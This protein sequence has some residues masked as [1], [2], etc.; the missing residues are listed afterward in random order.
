MLNAKHNESGNADRNRAETSH[1]NEN[2]N[3]LFPEK[4]LCGLSPSF[5]IHVPVSNLH[6]YSQDR[7]TYFPA[8]E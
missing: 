4:E 7:S 5:H 2:P 8:A 3:Y 6:I 1:C